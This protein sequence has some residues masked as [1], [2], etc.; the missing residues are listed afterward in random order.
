LPLTQAEISQAINN[1][2]M[3][4][5]TA[6][7]GSIDEEMKGKLQ[8]IVFDSLMMWGYSKNSPDAGQAEE[9]DEE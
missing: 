5:T 8:S 1:L 9:H 2:S 4:D 6:K 7:V 3:I